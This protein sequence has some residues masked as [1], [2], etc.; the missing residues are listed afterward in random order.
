MI[1]TREWDAIGEITLKMTK[2]AEISNFMEGE[3]Y[4]TIFFTIFAFNLLICGDD[5]INTKGNGAFLLS[6]GRYL[7]GKKREREHMV[8]WSKTID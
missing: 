5:A 4:C 6:A 3:N 8:E 2:V 7:W 1:A